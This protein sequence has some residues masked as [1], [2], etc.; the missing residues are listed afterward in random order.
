MAQYE[1]IGVVVMNHFDVRLYASKEY[2]PWVVSHFL[3]KW[4]NPYYGRRPL[5]TLLNEE[6]SSSDLTQIIMEYPVL[7][8]VTSILCF[9]NN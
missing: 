2:Y 3:A 1:A 4:I 9:F 8:I 7:Q 6:V 5:L